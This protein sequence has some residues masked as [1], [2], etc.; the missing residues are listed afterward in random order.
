MPGR[1]I[2][3]LLIFCNLLIASNCFCQSDDNPRYLYH[4]DDV[5]SPGL[6]HEYH[7]R[8]WRTSIDAGLVFGFASVTGITANYVNGVSAKT[9]YTFGLIEEMPIQSRSYID[10]G[11]EI[12]QDGL[13]FNSYFFAPGASFLY[14]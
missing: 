10:F 3:G 1:K 7:H 8:P 13:S 12:L 5:K 6:F 9:G 4:E 14:D 11:I 2:L